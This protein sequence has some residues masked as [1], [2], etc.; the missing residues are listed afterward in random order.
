AAP[1]SGLCFRTGGFSSIKGLSQEASGFSP[2]P[3]LACFGAQTVLGLGQQSF[4]CQVCG[5]GGHKYSSQGGDARGTAT[6]NECQR[7]RISDPSEVASSADML[8][9]SKGLQN[10]PAEQG[11][12]FL[13]LFQMILRFYVN[14]C[15]RHFH[16]LRSDSYP[17]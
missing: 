14:F 5:A 17:C 15:D 9:A 6:S 11:P 4:V 2:S 16:P 10:Q 3:G 7:P 1:G 8:N 12:E 13:D